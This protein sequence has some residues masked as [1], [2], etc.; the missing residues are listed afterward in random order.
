MTVGSAQFLGP[1]WVVIVEVCQCAVVTNRGILDSHSSTNGLKGD[2]TQG[3][4]G[5]ERAFAAMEIHF[6]QQD[7][8]RVLVAAVTRDVERVQDRAMVL[9]PE[10]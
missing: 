2:E 3:G 7:F 6:H 4:G 1:D 10:T 5:D 9:R 8:G